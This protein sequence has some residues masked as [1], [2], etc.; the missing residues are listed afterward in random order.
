MTQRE[1]LLRLSH[2]ISLHGPPISVMGWRS[3]AQEIQ[4]V[5]CR[6][7]QASEHER[8]KITQTSA[9]LQFMLEQSS[10]GQQAAHPQKL[11]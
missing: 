7:M 2:T 5:Q 6:V 10:D 4:F 9:F 11:V 8:R 1:L 3:K